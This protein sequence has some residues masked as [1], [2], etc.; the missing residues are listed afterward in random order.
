MKNFIKF[1]PLL[2]VFVF[3]GLI[4]LDGYERDIVMQH[5]C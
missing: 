2:G 5:L 1:I 3:I 4:I